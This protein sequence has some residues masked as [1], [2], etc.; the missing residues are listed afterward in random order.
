LLSCDA[1]VVIGCEEIAGTL[2][3][4]KRS[5]VFESVAPWLMVALCSLPVFWMQ[6]R[7]SQQSRDAIQQDTSEDATLD[8]F[9]KL[10][11]FGNRNLIADFL[12]LRFTQYFG[13][14]PLRVKSGYGLSYKY[15]KTVTDKDPHFENAYRVANLAVAYRMGRPDLADA[16]L[17]KGIQQNPDSYLLWQTRGFLHF[18]YTGDITKAVYCFRKNAGLA[19]AVGG[20]RLQHWG[21]YWLAMSRYLEASKS[22]VWTRRQ[23]W[24]EVYATSVD[25][26]TKALALNQLDA[27]GVLLR[28]DGRLVARYAVPLPEGLAKRFAFGPPSPKH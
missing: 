26:S 8:T 19:V 20:N 28:K 24:S 13:D 2:K 9:A 6:A 22:N 23:I 25:E 3:S 17:A 7:A 21:N 10:P 14:T 4:M 27:L 18:L 12:W 16:L 5:K 1:C 11:D 15:L